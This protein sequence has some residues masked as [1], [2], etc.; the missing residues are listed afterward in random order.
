MNDLI[1]LSSKLMN[2]NEISCSA[3]VINI[4]QMQAV[5]RKYL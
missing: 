4:A 3:Y 1:Y 5:I 2:F